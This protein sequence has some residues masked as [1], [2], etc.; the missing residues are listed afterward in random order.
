[1][2]NHQASESMLGYLFQLHCGLFL[3]LSDDNERVS[4][5]LEK[6]DD[7]TIANEKGNLSLYQLKLHTKQIGDLT[8]SSTDLW[9]TLKVWM[10]WYV[11]NP[12]QLPDT[13]F[14]IITNANAPQTSATNMLRFEK[15][16]VAS[17]Y[18]ILKNIAETSTNKNH[19]PYYNA[20]LSLSQEKAEQLLHNLIVVDNNGNIETTDKE[21]KRLLQYTIEPKYISNLFERLI[22][23]WLINAE[24]ML[25]S[26][27]PVFISRREV[28]SKILQIASEYRDDNLPIDEFD[29][30]SVPKI[31]KNNE[32][33]FQVQLRLLRTSTNRLKIAT[34]NYYR[35]FTQ[36]TKWINEEL[37]YIPELDNYET[38]LVEEWEYCFTQMEDKLNKTRFKTEATKRSMGISLLDKIEDK[39]IRIREKVSD[40]FVM[41]GSY[42]IL[43]DDLRVGWHI[44]YK[45]L[46]NH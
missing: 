34:K 26:D 45:T 7:V 33:L 10:D 32:K 18:R 46:L 23:W 22:G 4:I 5:C 43:A 40:P 31:D 27:S 25:I 20:F 1:M 14:T 12:E 15:R 24:D 9:R 8:D 3:L 41:R 16:D 13:K 6:Y 28:Q 17:A 42:H 44:E 19:M 36:R 37:A 11:S 30:A 39:D 29:E 2:P 35:A 38:R 21:I